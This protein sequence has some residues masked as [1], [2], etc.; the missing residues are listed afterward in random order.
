MRF[1]K[2]EEPVLCHRQS[3]YSSKCLV[4]FRVQ[5]NFV[6]PSL[7]VLPQ[8]LPFFPR[9]FHSCF[10]FH[11]CN[12][13]IRDGIGIVIVVIPL[14]VTFL[15]WCKIRRGNLKEKLR[16][17]RER[18]RASPRCE[19]CLIY[20]CY[21]RRSGRRSAEGWE[22]RLFADVMVATASRSPG[23][24][25]GRGR[26]ANRGSPQPR[27]PLKNESG[28]VLYVFV[29]HA[30]PSIEAHTLQK[31]THP[32]IYPAREFLESLHRRILSIHRV[33]WHPLIFS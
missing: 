33:H 14:R 4:H 2:Q 28:R 32:S 18:E 11:P 21:G 22:A 17:K 8:T 16:T 3:N 23:S 27:D 29:T 9:S 5:R 13:I 10:P 26:F 7:N 25:R 31:Q 24:P 6:Y 1:I 15:L 19:R 12:L 20:R 30:F